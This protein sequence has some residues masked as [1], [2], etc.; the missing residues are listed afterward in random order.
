MMAT[1]HLSAVQNLL[2]SWWY[3]YDEANFAQ[4]PDHFCDEIDYQSR[5]DTGHSGFEEVVR[6]GHRGRKQLLEGLGRHR[7]MGSYPVR[8]LCLN[9]H[10]TAARADEAD[11]RYYLL[12]T[13]VAAEQAV[14]IATANCEGTARLIDGEARIARMLSVFDLTESRPLAN[15][16]EKI[17][18]PR[19][20]QTSA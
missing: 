12:V 2:A 15:A 14:P 13:R 1:L 11:F 10:M 8:H 4:W 5:S 6:W 3:H 7:A 18:D 16:G 19:L 9:V 20:G 17:A